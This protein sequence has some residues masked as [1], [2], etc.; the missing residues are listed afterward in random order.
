MGDELY[1]VRNSLFVGNYHQAIAEGSNARTAMKK[2]DDVAAFNADKEALVARAQI[3]LGQFDAVITEHRA[4][5]SPLLVAVRYFAEFSRDVASGTD[6]AESLQ[7][8]LGFVSDVSG[9]KAEAAALAVAALITNRD[10]AG[11]LRLAS[12]WVQGLDAQ[13]PY[14]S[15]AIIELRALSAD[16]YLRLHRADL[17]EKEV[18]AMKTLDDEATLTILTAGQVALRQAAVKRDRYEEAAQNFQ[19]VSSRCGTSVLTL[20]LLALAN[21]G[22][23]RATEAEKNLID[24]LSKKSGDADTTANMVVVAAQVGKPI[25]QVQ[26]L[27]NQARSVPG[28]QWAKTYSAMEDRFKEAAAAF[29]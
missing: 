19:E 27:A 15:R 13:S 28:S 2:P 1:D 20:N 10:Y 7:K 16:A 6:P 26:R 22:R 23:G 24:A 14:Q 9:A 11:A 25:E 17:A 29:A 5:T 3:G 21:I 8:L 12:K 18:Q 4:A